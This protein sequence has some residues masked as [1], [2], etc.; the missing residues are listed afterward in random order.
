MTAFPNAARA[1]RHHIGTAVKQLAAA[2][3]ELRGLGADEDVIQ[4]LSANAGNGLA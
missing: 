3:D 1:A 4:G 2:V